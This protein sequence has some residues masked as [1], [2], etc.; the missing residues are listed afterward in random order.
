MASLN[1]TIRKAV[2]DE[3][4]CVVEFFDSH[5]HKMYHN[6][7]FLPS[8]MIRD[9]IGRGNVII[10]ES[11]AG[12]LGVA[13]TNGQTLWNLVVNKNYRNKGVGSTLLKS[14][15]PKY[16]RIKRYGGFPD[17]TNFYEKNGYH[18]LIFVPSAATKKKTILLAERTE[19]E[20]ARD[21]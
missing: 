9:H 1:V 13:L 10:A 7:G 17:P 16:V 4:K 6:P 11:D 2:P 14:I 21:M 15:D 12:I 8:G 20:P 18:Q 3:W 19:K 5:L